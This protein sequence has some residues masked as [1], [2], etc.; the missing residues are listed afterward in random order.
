MKEIRKE[1]T[2]ENQSEQKNIYKNKIVEAVEKIEDVNILIK[3]FDFIKT[4]LE[5]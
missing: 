2:E 5:E 4:W 3:I 1:Y